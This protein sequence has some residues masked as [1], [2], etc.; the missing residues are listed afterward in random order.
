MSIILEY[1]MKNRALPLLRFDSLESVL[2]LADSLIKG[3]LPLAAVTIRSEACFEGIEIIREKHPKMIIGVGDIVNITQ[4]EQSIERG[5][6]FVLSPIVN[7]EII[8]YCINMNILVMP[9]CCTPTEIAVAMSYG[10][11]VLNFFP[12]EALGGVSVMSAILGPFDDVKLIVTNGI[13]ETNLHDYLDNKKVKICGVKWIATPE[14]VNQGAFQ[15]IV[16]RTKS[17]V[18]TLNIK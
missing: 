18:E 4:A 17:L 14:M 11:E 12:N 10:A 2:P 3:G 1:M 8:D 5:A 9:G 6:Q 16:L 15:E 7:R 13:S